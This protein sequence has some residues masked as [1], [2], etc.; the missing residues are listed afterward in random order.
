M[1]AGLY[2]SGAAVPQRNHQ[3]VI[4]F[5]SLIRWLELD[6]GRVP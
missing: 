4:D 2:I 3:L 6:E 5:L 1:K